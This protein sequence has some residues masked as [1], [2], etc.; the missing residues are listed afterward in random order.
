MIYDYG[1]NKTCHSFYPSEVGKIKRKNARHARLARIMD[2]FLTVVFK[3]YF[4]YQVTKS[5]RQVTKLT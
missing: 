3:I 2:C 5:T 4:F 1:N